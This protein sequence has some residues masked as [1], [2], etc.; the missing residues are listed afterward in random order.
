M[1]LQARTQKVKELH[2]AYGFK[3]NDSGYEFTA[4]VNEQ[5]IAELESC[6]QNEQPIFSYLFK[7]KHVSLDDL[8]KEES[9]EVLIKI[10][11][12]AIKSS[13]LY[14]YYEWADFLAAR[15]NILNPPENFLILS[16]TTTFPFDK[17]QGK[18]KHFF[19]V[20]DFL[21][22]IVENADHRVELTSDIIEEIVF[23]HKTK[24]EIPVVLDE[25]SIEEGLDGFSIVKSLFTDNSHSEQKRSILKEVIFG[26]L[27]NINKNDRLIYLLVNFGEFSKR[28]SENYQLFVSEFSF[29][30]VRKEY[31]ESK[32]DYLTKLNDIFS[33][34]QTKMLGIPIS[35]AIASIKISPII[36][37]TSFWTNFFLLI[38]V[39]IYTQ[40]MF[41]LISNQRHTLDAVKDEY[42]SHMGRLKHQY[43]EQYDSI[44]DIQRDLDIRYDFQ[45][46]CLRSFNLMLIGLLLFV[47]VL[48]VFS[49][50][51]SVVLDSIF[52][53]QI[54]NAF[55]SFLCV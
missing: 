18:I 4:T 31:E 17:D 51:W 49:I 8:R 15:G 19:E 30:D 29:D 14:I 23:L 34:V 11:S 28:F 53:N 13:G 42:Q 45:A 46:N 47:I 55:L 44:K 21:K 41:I 2:I 10:N 7:R 1:D 40:M 6:E 50:P 24:I 48:F 52:E 5:L 9:P 22:I 37:L 35:L 12:E 20:S 43:S 26:L 33:S 38:A 36:D 54:V 27:N 32:R 39:I 16:D 25:T 3:R